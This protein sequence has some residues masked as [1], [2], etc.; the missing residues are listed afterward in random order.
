ML[1]RWNDFGALGRWAG[2]DFG[3]SFDDLDALRREMNRLFFDFE[4]GFSG[5]RDGW[6][7]PSVSLN[8]NGTSLVIRA[9]VPG[10]KPEKLDLSVDESTLTLKGEREDQVPEGYSVHRKER[11]AYKFARTLAL[12]A[13]VD[14]AAAEARFKDGIL[15]VTLPKAKEAQPRQISVRA[16]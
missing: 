7:W 3:R 12:P 1:S 10:M 16:G 11:V 5:E 4:T 2:R 15:T 14:S 6:T 8:D 13:K 9:E